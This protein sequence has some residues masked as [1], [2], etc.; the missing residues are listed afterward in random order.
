[1]FVKQVASLQIILGWVMFIPSLPAIIYHEWYSM[2]GFLLAGSLTTVIG[3]T[4]FRLFEKTDEP[5]YK[6]SLAIAAIGWL[7]IVILGALPYIIIAWITPIE[8]MQQFVP[9]GFN[10]TSSLINFR[11]PLHSIFEST[12]AFTTT[13][14]TMA[15]HEPSIGKSILFYRH[16]S[17]WVG[18]AGFIVMALAIFKQL[19]GQG[20]IKLY[21]S[22]ASVAKLRTNVIQT[23]R[24]I[25]KVYVV[26][27]MLVFI[28]L[29][30]YWNNFDS[31]RL[32]SS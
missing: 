16:F 21:S 27:T 30:I 11:N 1:M 8:I 7:M 24:A 22:E 5:E 4:F 3:Y 2:I 17:Q 25:W 23:A 6:H 12:S 14:L 31:T 10:Y 26:I 18:G 15:Y 19:P 29:F 28:Y 13:G 32:S 9:N 20:A